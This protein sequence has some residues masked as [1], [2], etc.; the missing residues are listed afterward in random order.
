MKTFNAELTEIRYV[1]KDW[2][3]NTLSRGDFDSFESAL[4]EVHRRVELEMIEDEADI[5]DDELFSNYV[6]DYR[7]VE[8]NNG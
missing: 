4:D 3:G 2:A 7:I 6:F 1:I 8:N 5:S